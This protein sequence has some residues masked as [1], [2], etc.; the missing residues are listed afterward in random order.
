MS[1]TKLRYDAKNHFPLYDEKPS[2]SRCKMPSCIFFS[3]I[4]CEKC[5]VNLCITSKRN[6]FYGYHHHNDESDKKKSV[7]R[8]KHVNQPV[9]A[10][11]V[12]KTSLRSTEVKIGENKKRTILHY[13][14]STQLNKKKSVCQNKHVNRPINATA[15]KEIS[16]RSIKMKAGEDQNCPMHRSS[17]RKINFMSMIGLNSAAKD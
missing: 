1:E 15:L 13:D 2:R 4:Y 6:C 3:H 11:V 9:T 12:K 7:L 16:L 5:E 8:S 17:S 10:T 14:P